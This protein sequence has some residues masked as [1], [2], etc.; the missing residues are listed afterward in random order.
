MAKL[1][2]VLPVLFEQK[3]LDHFEYA[4]MLVAS[5]R[6]EDAQRMERMWWDYF[7]D[8][9]KAFDDARSRAD[10]ASGRTYENTTSCQHKEAH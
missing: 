1:L 8:A 9:V 5:C 4:R 2:Q 3:W 10:A 7:D 6:R